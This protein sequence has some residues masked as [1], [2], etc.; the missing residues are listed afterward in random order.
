MINFRK[1]G[2]VITLVAPDGGVVSGGVYKIGQLIVVA[3]A[4]VAAGSNFEGKRIGEFSGMPKATGQ[5][6]SQGATLYWDN[7]AGKFTTTSSSNTRCGCATVA[8]L[9]A[10]TTGTVLLDGTVNPAS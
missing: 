4:T 9:S 8:A 5:A 7:S 3:V 6:W 1:R 2:D 10:D